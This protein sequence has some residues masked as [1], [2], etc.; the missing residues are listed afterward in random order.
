MYFYPPS[1]FLLINR[2]RQRLVTKV[3][4]KKSPNLDENIESISFLRKNKDSTR[5]KYRS[6]PRTEILNRF[7]IFLLKFEMS[8]LFLINFCH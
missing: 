4:V 1:W 2:L 5:K 7:S 6:A 3:N 8:G